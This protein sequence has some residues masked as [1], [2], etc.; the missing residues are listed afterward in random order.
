MISYLR[1][2]LHYFARDRELRFVVRVVRPASNDPVPEAVRVEQY[3]EVYRQA[4][5][6][7][8][9]VLRLKRL[10]NTWGDAAKT[11]SGPL[12]L[13][14]LKALQNPGLIASAE[15]IPRSAKDGLLDLA[16]ALNGVLF[17]SWMA[18]HVRPY[19]PAKSELP[20][21]LR[22]LLGL[23]S[24]RSPIPGKWEPVEIAMEPAPRRAG[25]PAKG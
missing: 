15:D 6:T 3:A 24:V 7:S 20:Q 19:S 22:S 25:I 10:P 23:S 17:A 21:R 2:L 13:A 1:Q 4:R 12:R 9:A 16:G 14:R 11:P 18:E 5:L 8:G